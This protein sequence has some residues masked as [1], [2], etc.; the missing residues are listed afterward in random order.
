MAAKSD[1]FSPLRS[2]G[3]SILLTWSL[4]NLNDFAARNPHDRQLLRRMYNIHQN[5]AN[6]LIIQHLSAI[7]P[8]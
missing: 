2:E 4:C 8:G 1:N 5:A 6:L 3:K 7:L